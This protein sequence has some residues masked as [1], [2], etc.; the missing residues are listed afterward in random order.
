MVQEVIP[1]RIDTNNFY[2]TIYVHLRLLPIFTM[3]ANLMIDVLLQQ[4]LI[5]ET[6]NLLIIAIIPLLSTFVFNIN[7]NYD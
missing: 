4:A 2:F 5:G 7:F 6:G 3:A 1:E